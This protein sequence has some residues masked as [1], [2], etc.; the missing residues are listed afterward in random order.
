MPGIKGKTG[1]YKR[2]TNPIKNLGKFGL[3]LGKV[4]NKGRAWTKEEKEKLRQAQI[5]SQ[6]GR[7]GNAWKGDIS[8]TLRTIHAKELKNWRIS[9]FERD[10]YTCQNC[11]KVGNYLEAHHI[12]E[13]INYPELRFDINNGITLCHDCHSLT[14]NYKHK[15]KKIKCV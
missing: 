4:W 8:R 15:A 6:S 14:E 2:K 12:K 7:K 11:R 13:W 5:K 3:G 9:I 10:S 1:I